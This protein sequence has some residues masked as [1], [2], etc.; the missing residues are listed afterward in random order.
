MLPS[1]GG[2]GGDVHEMKLTSAIVQRRLT[3]APRVVEYV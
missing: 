2:G 3:T 1:F